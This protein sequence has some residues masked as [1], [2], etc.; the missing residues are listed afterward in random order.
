MTTKEIIDH[1]ERLAMDVDS[2]ADGTDAI[3]ALA[4]LRLLAKAMT[5]AEQIVELKAR[6]QAANMPKN[7]S[8]NGMTWTKKDGSRKFVFDH[9][10][11]YKKVKEAAAAEMEAI[12]VKARYAFDRIQRGVDIKMVDGKLLNEETGELIEPAKVTFT[13]DS[14]VMGK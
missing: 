9:I 11:Q 6:E 1:V 8:H 2:G 14:L 13:K 3:D 12:A 10:A 5:T 4:Q 7:F